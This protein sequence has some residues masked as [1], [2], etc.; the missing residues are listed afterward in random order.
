MAQKKITELQ[1]ISEVSDSLSIPGDNGIQ[2]YRATAAQ[3]ATYMGKVLK[4]PV[5]SKT[6]TYAI[7][8]TDY[9]ILCSGSAFT[10]T[11]PTA[12][13][14]SGKPFIIKKTDFSLTNIITI[15]TTSS[16]TIDG[17]T[18]TTLNT[19]N[20]SV[21]LYSDGANWQILERV[22]PSEVVAYTP[23]FGAGFGTVSGV[24]GASRR[25]KDCLEFWAKWTNGT[26]ASN[27]A[28][29]TMGFG[30][31]S[32]NVTIDTA[33]V[34]TVAIVGAYTGSLTSTTHFGA[35]PVAPGSNATTIG[36]TVLNSTTGYGTG[37]VVAAAFCAS[38][39]LNTVHGMVPI[40][41]WKS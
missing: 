11:L 16:Q 6:T 18:T 7:A 38:S 33:K 24:S 23:V 22:I 13:G 32:G 34:P 27:T 19:Q 2:T 35:F 1:L 9:A 30:G 15:A 12:V 8:N 40:V 21:Y 14:I 26:V 37:A 20:E 31:T 17:V 5:T 25:V 3:I 41:G 28:S 10:V 36:F 39:S 4:F 29:M